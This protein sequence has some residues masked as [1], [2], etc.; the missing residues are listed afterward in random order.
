MG[1]Q[2]LQP[3][4]WSLAP[5][6]LR[7]EIP[8]PYMI[9]SC[10]SVKESSQNLVF[11]EDHP[12]VCANASP[13]LHKPRSHLRHTHTPLSPSARIPQIPFLPLLPPPHNKQ[14]FPVQPQINSRTGSEDRSISGFPNQGYSCHETGGVCLLR[15][16]SG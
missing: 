8:I 2:P 15:E 6:I 11:G 7:S 1:Y 13:H 10:R 14:T 4:P 12:L 16:N 3:S 5:C 9:I